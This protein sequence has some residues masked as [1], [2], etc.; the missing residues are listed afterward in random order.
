MTAPFTV[1]TLKEYFLGHLLHK[2]FVLYRPCWK[3][4]PEQLGPFPKEEIY[5]SLRQMTRTCRAREDHL[6][7]SACKLG[8]HSWLSLAL[9]GSPYKSLSQT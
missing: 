3:T 7:F 1:M 5:F 8:R 6:L 9:N 2:A 4:K